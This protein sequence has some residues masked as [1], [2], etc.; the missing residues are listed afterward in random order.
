MAA[1]FDAA[2]DEKSRHGE[3]RREMAL[4]VPHGGKVARLFQGHAEFGIGMREADAVDRAIATLLAADGDAEVALHG[5]AEKHLHALNPAPDGDAAP[6]DQH[7][8]P[9]AVGAGIRT[10]AR[11]DFLSA[12]EIEDRLLHRVRLRWV[13]FPLSRASGISALNSLNSLVNET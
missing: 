9:S 5:Q 6:L 1:G 2:P 11:R 3:E 13:L 10:C 8:A 7:H 12:A 4:R